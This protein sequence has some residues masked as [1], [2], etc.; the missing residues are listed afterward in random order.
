MVHRRQRGRNR[1]KKLVAWGWQYTGNLEVLNGVSLHHC[2]CR[3]VVHGNAP[4][5][6]W[7]S[8]C[9]LGYERVELEHWRDNYQEHF[10]VAISS[11]STTA[12]MRRPQSAHHQHHYCHAVS[13]SSV[14]GQ[15]HNHNYAFGGSPIG[16][17]GILTK[18]GAGV[19]TLSGANSYSGGTTNA[20]GTLQVGADNALGSGLV[21]LSGGALS[22]DGATRAHWR[23]MCSSPPPPR[24]AMP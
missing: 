12:F 22:S 9:Q 23:I 11:R 4:D 21:T 6:V 24:W 15:Q 8:K 3:R 19:L 2:C 5:L 14:D 13:P 16:G 20:G 1:R 18:S 17:A 7:Q 10:G